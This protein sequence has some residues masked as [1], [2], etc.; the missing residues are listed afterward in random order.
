MKA[1]L[2]SNVPLSD[3]D[4]YF[5]EYGI[6]AENQDWIIYSI[7]GTLRQKCFISHM[8]ECLDLDEVSCIF[9]K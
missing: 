9:R 1:R 4:I 3:K 6:K 7:S 2:V 5:G 8:H